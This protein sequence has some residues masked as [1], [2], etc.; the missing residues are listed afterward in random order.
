MR[1]TPP[2]RI[3]DPSLVLLIGAAGSGKSTF[4][5]RHFAP[6]EILSSDSLRAALSG[7]AADQSVSGAAFALLHRRAA[8]RLRAGQLTVVDATNVDDRSR[9]SLHAIA[10][11]ASVPVVGFVLDLPAE[12]VLARNV[13]RSARTVPGHVV[14]RQLAALRA[15]VDS[16]RLGQERFARLVRIT[17]PLAADA[18]VI[19]REPAAG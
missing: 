5:A 7:D 6:A 13:D 8:A 1:P 10:R 15:C 9:S 19:V 12:I 17:D 18:L 14:R 16:G 11:A 2:T 4:A 3:P